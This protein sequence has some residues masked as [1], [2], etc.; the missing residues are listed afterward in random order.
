MCR[1]KRISAEK[2]QAPIYR[3]PPSL[4]RVRARGGG[5]GGVRVCVCV[6]Q[7]LALREVH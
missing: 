2:N 3:C 4:F 6:C 7:P 5:G 1:M